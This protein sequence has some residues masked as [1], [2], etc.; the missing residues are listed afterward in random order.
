MQ[1]ASISYK[2]NGAIYIIDK[3][4][5]SDNPTL[6]QKNT[7]MYEMKEDKSIDVDSIDDINTIEKLNLI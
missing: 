5:F 4:L 6:F 7:A 3:K 2:P 1:T